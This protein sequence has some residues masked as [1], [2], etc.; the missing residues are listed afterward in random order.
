MEKI[1]E[2]DLI[3]IYNGDCQKIM[4]RLK[5]DKVITSP[6]YNIVRPN[7][8]DRGYDLYQDGIPNEEY[9]DWTIKTFEIYNNILNKNG[10]V[11]YNLSYGTENTTLMSLVVA[12]IIKRTNFTLADVLVWKKFSATPNN[13][14]SNKMTRIVEFIYVFCRKDEF[15]NFTSNKKI[16]GH[17]EKT[18]QAIYEN[19][20]NFFIAPNNDESQ[21]LNKATFST[22][23]V[24]NIIE[25]YVLKTDIV[26]DNFS[27]TGTT[28]IAC[29]NNGIKSIGIEL[30]QAQC[31]YAVNRIK[32]G[33]AVRLF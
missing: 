18:N 30:S 31:E 26:L 13:V 27:G 11:I 19:V 17:I 3:E 22:D 4:P 23:F 33:I 28:L 2:N 25:R 9:I 20:F 14:S 6:P 7:S 10:A 16:V 1:Y 21:E 24:E 29:A 12:E 5:V 32:K 8:Q 15:Y